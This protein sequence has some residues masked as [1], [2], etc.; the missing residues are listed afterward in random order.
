MSTVPNRVKPGDLITS[1]YFNTIVDELADLERRL[2]LLE[3]SGT[4]PGPIGGGAV[5]ID[6][7]APTTDLRIGQELT[8][9]GRNFGFSSGSQSVFFNSARAT[10]FK[11]GSSDTK[12]IIEI[13][14]VPGVTEAG[15]QVSLTVA[16]FSSTDTR[17]LTLKPVQLAEQGNIALSF[18]SVTPST[19]TAGSPPGPT[20]RYQISAPILLPVTVTITPTISI[21]SLQASLQVL[22]GIGNPLAGD[23]KSVV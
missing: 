7:F 17:S 19:I 16:N 2:A 6:S 10:V 11:T 3:G 9:F 5:V 1:A 13:P 20:F 21:T 18:L 8:I 14:D 22:D 23:R 12:L 4:G 15:T